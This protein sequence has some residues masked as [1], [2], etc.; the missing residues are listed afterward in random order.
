M[1]HSPIV[2][3]L[4]SVIFLGLFGCAQARVESLPVAEETRSPAAS[5]VATDV[6]SADRLT[7]EQKSSLQTLD[8]P[9]VVP[10]YLPNAFEISEVKANLC[11]PDAPQRGNC[12]E[13]SSYT[14]VYRN[15]QNTCLLVNGVSGG[16][17]GGSS[18]FEFQTPTEALGEVTILFGPPTGENQAPSADQ[19][20]TPQT[21]LGSFPAALSGAISFAALQRCGRRRRVLPR[22]LRL[23]RK[24]QR[25]APGIRKSRSVPR[26]FG[27]GD[28]V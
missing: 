28:R 20:T 13:G 21:S 24:R 6:A 17:G 2:L 5:P 19:L 18:E 8:I 9:V 14:L 12:R 7:P 3:A 22:N 23:R 27:I 10:G 25:D 1:S 11:G 4:Q 26:G 16:V 15:A